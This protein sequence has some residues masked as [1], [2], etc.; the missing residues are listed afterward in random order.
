MFYEVKVLF[1]THDL[2]FFG[3][4]VAVAD[5]VQQT[6]YHHTAQLLVEVDA[7][8]PGIVSDALR[9]DVHLARDAAAS[10]TVVKSDDVRVVVVV[11][12]L[13]V[14]AA[15]VFVRTKDIVDLGDT[16]LLL[17]GDGNEPS[18][19]L[20]RWGE[21]ELRVLVEKGNGVF[22]LLQGRKFGKLHGGGMS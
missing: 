19:P 14:D 1:F 10:S 9:A 2:R 6:V 7:E 16:A 5:E 3:R 13:D 11:E 12:E 4:F 22:V 15:Q 21:V 20:R 17:V 8:L 18:L